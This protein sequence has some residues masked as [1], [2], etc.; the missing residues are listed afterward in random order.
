MGLEFGG[1]GEVARRLLDAAQPLRG[2]PEKK[3]QVGVVRGRF[4]GFLNGG[5]ARAWFP[6]TEVCEVYQF[7]C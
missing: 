4:G 3:E 6:K 5:Q 2:F 7:E 1:A